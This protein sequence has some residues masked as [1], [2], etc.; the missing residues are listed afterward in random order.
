MFTLQPTSLTYEELLHYA[1][2]ALDR[3]ESLPLH[4]R[5]ELVKRAYA[6]LDDNK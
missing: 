5:Q 1:Q 6:Q 4:W 3:K 2:M